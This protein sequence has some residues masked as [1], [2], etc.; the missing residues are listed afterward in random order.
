MT[1][2]A[3]LDIGAIERSR[4][5][6]ALTA[7]QQIALALEKARYKPFQIAKIMGISR[8]NASRL[9]ARAHAA[10]NYLRKSAIQYLAE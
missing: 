7:R 1:A 3:A 8:E 5:P 9:L 10:D 6:T 4:K 2:L